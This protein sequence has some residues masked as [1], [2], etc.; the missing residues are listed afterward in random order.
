V[1]HIVLCDDHPV[2]VDALGVVLGRRGFTVDAVVTRVAQIAPTVAR[3]RPE[4]CLIDRTF[5]AEDGLAQIGPIL[6]ASPRTRVLMLTAD[7]NEATASRAL[8]AGASGYLC[9]TAGIDAVVG[10]IRGVLAGTTAVRLTPRPAP[11]LSPQ[12]ADAHRLAGYLTK[13]ERECLALLV[14][15]LSSDAIAERLGVSITTVRTHVQAVLTKLG[16]HSRLEAASFAVRHS[17]LGRAG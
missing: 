14:D 6:A 4:I 12:D 9:K 3:H 17:L 15:G 13:R 16:V 11:R 1:P 5:G 7:R 2:F 10:A 8:A